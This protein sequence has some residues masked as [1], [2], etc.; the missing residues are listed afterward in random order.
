MSNKLV[1]IIV[2][3]AIGLGLG[4]GAGFVGDKFAQWDNISIIQSGIGRFDNNKRCYVFDDE[5]NIIIDYPYKY[6]KRTGIIFGCIGALIGYIGSIPPSRGGRYVCSDMYPGPG[7]GGSHYH[8]E[9]DGHSQPYD[10]GN[11][12]HD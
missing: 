3:G 9:D 6:T 7:L 5:N 2:G 1:N 11:E 12:D 4:G 10:H 8:P